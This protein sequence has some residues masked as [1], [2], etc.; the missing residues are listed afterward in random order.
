MAVSFSLSF[1]SPKRLGESVFAAC[2]AMCQDSDSNVLTP[3]F[4]LVNSSFLTRCKGTKNILND[5]IPE[6][7]IMVKNVK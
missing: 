5:Q 7:E 2:G 6:G 1:S 4:Q 3:D